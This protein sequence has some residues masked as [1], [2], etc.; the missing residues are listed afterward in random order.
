MAPVITG[1]NGRFVIDALPVSETV[2]LVLQ[3]TG[4]PVNITYRP[5]YLTPVNTVTLSLAG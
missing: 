1:A 5:D 2:A 3:G 4:S